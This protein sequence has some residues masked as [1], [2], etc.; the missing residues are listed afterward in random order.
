MILLITSPCFFY[1]MTR[2]RTENER[3]VGQKTRIFSESNIQKFVDIISLTN[4]CEI[5]N[6]ESGDLNCTLFY[7]HMSRFYSESFPLVTISRKRQK[8]RPWVTQA[9]VTSIRQKNKL[10]RKSVEKPVESNIVKY[11]EYKKILN[12]VLKAAEENYYHQLLEERNNSAKNLWKRFGPILNTSK[13]QRSNIA[14]LLVK[15]QKVT[16]GKL[17]AD[18]LNNFFSNI[19]RDLDQKIDQSGAC[20]RKFL[21][22]RDCQSFSLPQSWKL[23]F[24][25]YWNWNWTVQR[26]V[27][28]MDSVQNWSH[29][30]ILTNLILLKSHRCTNNLKNFLWTITA[31]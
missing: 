18:A 29:H 4:W 12:V 15:G 16:D 22:D 20:F 14:S 13:T 19:G 30:P 5:M 23:M 3:S 9:L 10:Y 2:T 7:E 31:P 21:K 26:L 24:A 25:N 27:D 28:Q 8:D 11:K 17:I 1:R 6:H